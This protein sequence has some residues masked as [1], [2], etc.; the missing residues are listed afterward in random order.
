MDNE[1]EKSNYKNNCMQLLE[2]LDVY[3]AEN[4]EK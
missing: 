2:K 4:V 3:L 1:I